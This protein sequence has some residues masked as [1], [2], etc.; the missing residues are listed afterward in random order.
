MIKITMKNNKLFLGLLFSIIIFINCNGKQNN[1]LIENN[2]SIFKIYNNDIVMAD[3]PNKDT[4]NFIQL[5]D[6]NLKNMSDTNRNDILVNSSFF[7][8]SSSSINDYVLYFNYLLNH[9]DESY[10][11]TISLYL[12]EMFVKYPSKFNEFNNYLTEL[13]KSE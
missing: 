3:T 9:R 6:L 13:K 4:V 2:R 12:Y 5:M 10:D 8:D 1:T 7:K 11:E